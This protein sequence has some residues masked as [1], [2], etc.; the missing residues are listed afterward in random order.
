M[1]S[2]S[3]LAVVVPV[4]ETVVLYFA[5]HGRQAEAPDDTRE[6]LRVRLRKATQLLRRWQAEVDGD[7]AEWPLSVV[8]GP[9]QGP[10]SYL[11]GAKLI[12]AN[13]AR[14]SS[15][16][17]NIFTP[18][19]RPAQAVKPKSFFDDMTGSSVLLMDHSTGRQGG[20]PARAPFATKA[21]AALDVAIQVG[22]HGLTAAYTAVMDLWFSRHDVPKSDAAKTQQ[23]R[24]RRAIERLCLAL[25][26]F[27]VGF[28]G[29]HKID[30]RNNP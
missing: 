8:T 16:L 13:G 3:T 27:V 25:M 30:A 11:D 4:L 24:Q 2:A 5:G 15:A 19:S 28:F 7:Q 21:A 12:L 10:M 23:P 26:R 17:D 29:S 9:N 6:S 22:Q 18:R 14:Q 20:L 1:S